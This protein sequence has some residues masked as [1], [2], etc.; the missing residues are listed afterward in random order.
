MLIW[1]EPDLTEFFG[2]VATFDEDAHST[3][4]EVHRDGLR[5]LVSIFDFEDAV[6]VSLFRDG[7]PKPLLTIRQQPCAHVH[8]TQVADAH[9]CFEAGS[10]EIQTANNMGIPP[11]LTRGVRVDVDPQL[12]VKLFP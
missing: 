5:L 12:Q 6:H 3:S 1:S 11:V 10:P 8:I 7:L 2:V 9:F 4:F